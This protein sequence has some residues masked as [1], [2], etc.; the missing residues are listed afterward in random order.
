MASIHSA[1]H[2]LPVQGSG[3]IGTAWWGMLCL[4][5]TEA[6]LFAF[7]IFSF[8]YLGS[9][10]AADWPPGGPPALRLALPNT[11]LLILSSIVLE[12][13]SRGIAR[14]Q[15]KRWIG[16]LAATIVMGSA[17]IAIQLTEWSNKT[18][19]FADD[20]Y[21]S[22]YF[23]LTGLHLA[24]VAAGVIALAAVLVWSIQ[25]R[26]TPERHEPATLAALY[27]H[28]VDVVWLTVFTVI[29]IVPR[30]S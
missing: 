21:S 11:V 15:K 12:W 24:H 28:F 18:F 17:F 30:L 27:W 5:A 10:T 26:F 23:S 13:S 29:Y 14:R 7:F 9:Q 8:L 19:K 22:S 3:R 2:A 16:G 25:G 1:A 6:L 20:A 4:I